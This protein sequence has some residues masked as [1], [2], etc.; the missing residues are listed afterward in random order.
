MLQLA[1][2]TCIQAA[3]G[4]VLV[5]CERLSVKQKVSC[6]SWCKGSVL[7]RLH[8]ALGCL[9]GKWLDGVCST[10]P[11]SLSMLLSQCSPW[12]ACMETILF[13]G[14]MI[15]CQAGLK[16]CLPC[17]LHARTQPRTAGHVELLALSLALSSG[18][19]QEDI[20]RLPCLSNPHWPCCTGLVKDTVHV[21]SPSTKSRQEDQTEG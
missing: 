9:H 20:Q 16:P 8:L 2:E 11:L 18:M 10:L 3:R 21:I 4:G 5:R 17:M 19:L 7:G 13:F 15:T 14:P 12:A 6:D 1:A